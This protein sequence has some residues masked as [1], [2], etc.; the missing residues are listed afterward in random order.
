MCGEMKMKRKGL[1]VGMVFGIGGIELKKRYASCYDT[2]SSS[3]SSSPIG[4]IDASPQLPS[5]TVDS[6]RQ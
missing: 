5:V 2:F 3:I 1:Y 6:V 4:E